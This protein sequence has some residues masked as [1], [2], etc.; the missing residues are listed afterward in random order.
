MIDYSSLVSDN[1]LRV[2]QSPLW[3]RSVLVFVHGDL[4]WGRLH[5][6]ISRSTTPELI[7][8]VHKLEEFFTQQR[9]SS[10]RALSAFGTMT[11]ASKSKVKQK[12]EG[13][14]LKLWLHRRCFFNG[15]W[16]SIFSAQNPAGLIYLLVLISG[17]IMHNWLDSDHSHSS[18]FGSKISACEICYMRKQRLL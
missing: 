4:T 9:T 10:K 5:L 11:S 6:M 13:L 12:E 3:C 18:G 7:K 16:A 14:L 17:S 1:F 15:F 8:M 2:S